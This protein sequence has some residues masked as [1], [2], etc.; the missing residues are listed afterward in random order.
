MWEL[1]NK[2][3]EW[4]NKRYPRGNNPFKIITC[5]LEECGELASEVNHFEDEGIKRRKYGEPVKSKMA[6]E[7]KNVLWTLNR[8][9][10]YY[11]LEDELE[12]SLKESYKKMVEKGE[13]NDG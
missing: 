2:T 13:G 9:I 11:D 7:I 5:L 10:K 12:K 4:L 3:T 1:I 6:D 8:L